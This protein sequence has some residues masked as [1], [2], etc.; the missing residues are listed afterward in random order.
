[1]FKVSLQN[2]VR[3]H[4]CGGILVEPSHVITAAHCRD[5]RI[6]VVCIPCLIGNGLI[7][8][9]LKILIIIFFVTFSITEIRNG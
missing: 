6:P 3:S 9:A 2:F 1:M 7:C 8:F 5:D 4:V